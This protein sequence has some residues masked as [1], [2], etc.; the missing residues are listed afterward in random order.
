MNNLTPAQAGWLTLADIKATLFKDLERAELQVQEYIN[1]IDGNPLDVV[2]SNIKNAKSVLSEAKSKRLEFTRLIDEK[3]T[4]PSMLYEKRMLDNI[5][6][7]TGIELELRKLEESKVNNEQA[8]INEVSAYRNHIVNEWFRIAAEYRNNLE[9]GVRESYTNCLRD[10][11]D[12]KLIPDMIRNT[13]EIIS[14]F[15]LPAFNK[16]NRV[17]I[18]DGQAKEIFDSIDKYEPT[19]DLK[20]ITATIEDVWATYPYDLANAENA[21]KAI[22]EATAKKEAETLEAIALEVATNTLIASAEVVVIDTPK[23]K[24]ELKIVVVESEEWA[25]TILINFIRLLPIVA[26]KLRVKSWAKLSIAQMAEAI[27]K[28]INENGET[29]NG[30]KTEEVCK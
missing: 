26:P 16:F 5:N 29:I 27:N 30:L 9:K 19:S 12:A 10:R 24:R 20:R 4:A 17:L 1:G 3:L 28:H 11:H 8:Y 23:V 21:I 22:E 15:K 13:A 2:Q 6:L 18:T 7:A 25:K 14:T